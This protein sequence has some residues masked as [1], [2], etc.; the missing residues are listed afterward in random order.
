MRANFIQHGY[1]R[2]GATTSAKPVSVHS[3]QIVRRKMTLVPIV[4]WRASLEMLPEKNLHPAG[5][6]PTT[7][8]FGGRHSIQLSYGCLMEGPS[9]RDLAENIKRKTE[10]EQSALRRS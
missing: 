1:H 9:L 6:E 5:V 3:I 10:A 8:G 7:Y 2:T 4:W